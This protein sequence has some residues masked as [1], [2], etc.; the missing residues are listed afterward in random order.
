MNLLIDADPSLYEESRINFI[1]VGLPP[2]IRD[3]L[4]KADIE[5]HGDLMAELSHLESVVNRPKNR[6]NSLLFKTGKGNQQKH[7]ENIYKKS[8]AIE[9]IAQFVRR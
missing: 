3:R 1:V 5:S 9:N 2:F 8:E 7:Q 6:N 4:N